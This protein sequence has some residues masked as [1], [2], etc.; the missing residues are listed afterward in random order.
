[1]VQEP[2]EL[3]EVLWFRTGSWLRRYFRKYFLGIGSP[4]RRPS[5]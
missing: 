3:P 2:G 1:M 4:A 5:G